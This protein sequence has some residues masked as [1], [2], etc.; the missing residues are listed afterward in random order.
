MAATGRT[1]SPGEMRQTF[2][3][4]AATTAAAAAATAAAAAADGAPL[5]PAALL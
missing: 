1:R 3:T 2:E 4:T 5:P